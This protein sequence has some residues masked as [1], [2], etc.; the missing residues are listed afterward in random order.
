MYTQLSLHFRPA[1]VALA[2]L[3][4]LTAPA[5]ASPLAASLV[6]PSIVPAASGSASDVQ[7]IDHRRDRRCRRHQRCGSHY[8][9]R[10]HRHYHGHR[11]HR[12]VYPRFYIGPLYPSYRYVEPHRHYRRDFGSAHI[13]WC[14]NRYRSYRAW[15]NTFQPYHG[16]RRQCWSPYNR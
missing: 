12:G 15:D 14:Y 6:R 9:K 11:R 13:A 10:H 16:P 7:M 8:W 4:G 1:M 5:A 2:V 3:A